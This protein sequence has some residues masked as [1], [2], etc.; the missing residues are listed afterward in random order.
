MSHSTIIGHPEFLTGGKAFFTVSNGK[1]EHFTFRI[2]KRESKNP[3]FPEPTYWASVLKGP[4]N[5]HNYKTLGAYE[6]ATQSLKY[7]AGPSKFSA[8]A[9]EFLT[10]VWAIKRVHTGSE[11]PDGYSIQHAGKCCVC[12]RKLTTPESIA[13]GIGPVCAGRN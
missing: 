12:A 13:A 5:Y 10:F 1:G 9:V 11:L 2:S 8:C 6:P 4:D 7:I 3:R